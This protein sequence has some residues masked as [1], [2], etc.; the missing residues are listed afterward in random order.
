M[1]HDER[2]QG[3]RHEPAERQP[4]LAYDL[5][6][7]AFER[8]VLERA[9]DLVH[10]PNGRYDVGE[11]LAVP[12]HLIQVHSALEH[13]VNRLDRHRLLPGDVAGQHVQCRVAV[14]RSE[15]SAMKLSPTLAHRSAVVT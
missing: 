8:G 3:V 12:V 10:G 2:L 14:L 9:R 15:K 7:Q 13:Q 5:G 6:A 1:P 11:R 4:V